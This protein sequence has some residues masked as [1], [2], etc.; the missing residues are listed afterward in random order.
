MIKTIIFDLSEVLIAGLLGVEK[1]ISAHLAIPEEQVVAAFNT[2]ALQDLF[3]GRLS[4]DVFLAHILRERAWGIPLE[5]LKRMIR[6]NFHRRVPRMEELLVHLD[7]GYELVL[8]SDHAREW[9][10]YIQSIH[11]FLQIFPTRFFSFEL[12]QTKRY[13]ST[14]QKVLRSL[15]RDPHQCWFIDDSP[16]NI[17]AARSIGLPSIRFTT[18]PALVSEL[19][20]RGLA[21]CSHATHH[22]S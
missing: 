4:E 8:L 21:F 6:E 12:Q 10:A 5:S 11:P 3:C 18:A 16:A 15:N 7:R 9:M 22:F 14:F 17:Q 1:S 2:P 19:E 13:P 20:S